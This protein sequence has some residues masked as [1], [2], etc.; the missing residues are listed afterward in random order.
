MRFLDDLLAILLADIL[1]LVMVVLFP[2]APARVALGLPF[3]FF[4]PG[5]VL[6]SALY[7]RQDDLGGIERLA[8]GLGLSLAIVPLMGLI[9]DYTPWGI[10]P[11]PFVIA[12]TV[13]VV[14]SS[15]VTVHRRKQL[16][17][18][19]RFS[20]DVRSVHQVLRRLPWSAVAAWAAVLAL[21]LVLGFRLGLLG[22]SRLGEG[23]T[24]FYTL[25][26]GDGAGGYPQRLFT[27][28]AAE[29][30]LGIINHEGR[31]AQYSV[32][33]RVGTDLLRTLGPIILDD[34]RKWEERVTFSPRRPHKRARVQFLLFLDGSPRA[35]RET[36]LWVQ[37]QTL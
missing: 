6:V 26:P 30:V 4:S 34:S 12:L 11:V 23:F 13:F 8:L 24:E 10:R 9:L 16:S 27:G 20:A 7:P 36:H 28:Q 14:A 35:Y 18:S 19:E 2:D 1:L 33:V 17:V 5:Y 25:V 37:V 31:R 21:V 22:G 3:V 32:Q 29:V 15:L